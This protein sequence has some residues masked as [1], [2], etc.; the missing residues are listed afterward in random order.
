M[1]MQLS[2]G[3]I[4]WLH[5]GAV[6]NGG[7]EDPIPRW[8]PGNKGVPVNEL[9]AILAI[10]T[11]ALLSL[12]PLRQTQRLGCWLGRR[13][14]RKGDSD[15]IYRVTRI[16]IETCFPELDST[17]RE[18]L[19]KESLEQTGCSLAEMGISWFWSPRRVLAKV[20]Q[21]EGEELI[22]TELEAGR[23]ILLIA[24]HLGNWEVMNLYLSHHYPVTAMYKPPK[25][26]LLDRMIRKRRARLGSEMAPADARG[27]RM[28]FKALRRAG[29]VGILPDQEPDPKGGVFAPF[30]GHSALTMKLL[31]QLAAQTGVKVVCGYGRRL[32]DGAGFSLHFSAAESGINSRDLQ[33][34]VTAMNASIERCVNECPAQY[35]W[36]YKRFHTAEDGSHRFYK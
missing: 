27:V 17:A 36:E 20:R 6:Y 24:P 22:R 12:L 13:I 11:M 26:K 28:V 31:P 25:L 3:V 14:H 29:V 10:F 35:Q 32:P 4:G 19:I 23:G 30:F 34:A 15:R 1:N 5:E 16:N 7:P 2:V 33:E 18:Q 21:V 8:L 9:K